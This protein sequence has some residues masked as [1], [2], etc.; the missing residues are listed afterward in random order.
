MNPFSVFTLA[1]IEKLGLPRSSLVSKNRWSSKWRKQFQHPVPIRSSLGRDNSLLSRRVINKM[2][3]L[4]EK[5][6]YNYY[7]PF[8]PFSL[9]LSSTSSATQWNNFSFVC[10]FSLDVQK[11]IFITGIVSPKSHFNW[12]IQCCVDFVKTL[13]KRP[14]ETLPWPLYALCYANIH[15][16]HFACPLS[17]GSIFQCQMMISINSSALIFT[18]C[19]WTPNKTFNACPWAQATA[20][21]F[22][23]VTK[24]WL[25]STKIKA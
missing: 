16:G 21:G 7:C 14:S 15:R 24:F 13:I 6:Y 5:H 4:C 9:S 20:W 12:L 1:A 22:Q 2:T 25:K 17:N 18:L 3:K 10:V 19:Q 23:L 8:L 11:V